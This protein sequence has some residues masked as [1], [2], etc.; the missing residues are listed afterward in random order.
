MLVETKSQV[1][2]KLLFLY[3]FVCSPGQIGSVT[4]SS[5][6]LANKMVCSVPW[7]QI[8]SIAELGAGTGAITKHIQAVRQA[9][10]KVLLFEKD[11]YLQQAL[12]RHYPQFACY[13]DGRDLSFAMRQESIEQLD[14]IISGLPF[15]NFPQAIRD[16]LMNQIV[17][18]LK[19]GG[20]FIAFQYSLQMKSQLSEYFDIEAVHWVPLNLPPAFVYVCRK[21]G[22]RQS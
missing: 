7:D 22:A 4:P 6:Y 19:T 1:H 8:S 20:L 12:E 14:A 13:S 10:T 3:K 21:K 15:F 16:Q 18:S 17:A 2:E 11:P 9:N 5:R